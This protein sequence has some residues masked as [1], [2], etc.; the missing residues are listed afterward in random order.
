MHPFLNIADRAA[1]DAGKVIMR[2][3]E[4]LDT[5]KTTE[6]Q[7]N[8]FVT[9]IDQQAEQIIVEA[10][11]KAY[12][13]HAILAEESGASEAGNNDITWIIDPIDGTANFIHGF[14]QFAVSIAIKNKE[15]IEHGLIYDPVKQE[16]FTASHG[17][18]AQL[19]N[20]RLRVSTRSELHG[21]LIGTG[22]PFRELSK[23]D[24]YLKILK[25][26]MTQAGGIRR[27]GAAT[28][29]LAYVAAGRLDGF[30]EFGLSPWDIAAGALMVKE[31]GGLVSDDQ[32]GEEYL[33]TGNIVAG[34]MKL[35]KT[36]LQTV[37]GNLG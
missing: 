25:I 36:L 31:A 10:I 12:P 30:W 14:P 29:D 9:N 13:N 34:N 16:V 26:L 23:L 7:H 5:I 27:A 19:N 2:A 11:R 3:F 18:G 1:R 21:S 4:R 28:L 35:F 20:R 6:K 17:E 37:K 32:G 8:D 22:F 24:P 33:T 15:R